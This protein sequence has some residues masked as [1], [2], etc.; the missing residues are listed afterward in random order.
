MACVGTLRTFG[1]PAPLTLGVDAV[2]K[3]FSTPISGKKM[4]QVF[5]APFR[6]F[7]PLN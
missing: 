4:A 5:S 2:E 7:M 1:A 6:F 3:P